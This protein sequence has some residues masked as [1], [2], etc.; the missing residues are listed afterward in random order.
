MGIAPSALVLGEM[1]A[2]FF[3]AGPAQ[4]SQHSQTR[5]G[6]TRRS[7]ILNLSTRPGRAKLRFVLEPDWSREVGLCDGHPRTYDR[8][9]ESTA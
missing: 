4:L 2:L 1:T 8:S 3:A 9:M 5:K 6:L 7:A